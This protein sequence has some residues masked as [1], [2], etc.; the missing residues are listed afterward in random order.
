MDA[1]GPQ[2]AAPVSTWVYKPWVYK[3]HFRAP[4][5]PAKAPQTS[6]AKRGRNTIMAKKIT[7]EW[8][9]RNLS[10]PFPTANDLEMLQQQTGI[11]TTKRMHR[12][13]MHIRS[14][15]MQWDGDGKWN[16]RDK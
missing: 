4:A 6:S 9:L 3:A 12:L 1:A 11:D 16:V 7:L 14:K 15:H 5:A 10:D 2:E 13:V 8:L